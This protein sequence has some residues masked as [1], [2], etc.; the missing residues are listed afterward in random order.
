[1]STLLLWMTTVLMMPLC[2]MAFGLLG[3]RR[4]AWQRR[5]FYIFSQFKQ[6]EIL[7]FIEALSFSQCC[8]FS[9][10][11]P[12]PQACA[13]PLSSLHLLAIFVH[14][15]ALQNSLQSNSTRLGASEAGRSKAMQHCNNERRCGHCKS[16]APH[17]K[18]AAEE[19]A[20]AGVPVTL[21][22]ID[23]DANRLGLV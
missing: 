2:N 12:S 16:L 23:A 21:A 1:M 20:V 19:L 3:D 8:A 18:A 11:L 13:A 7:G 6:T 9:L 5:C 4:S 15:S 14:S 22:M 10:R 17:W